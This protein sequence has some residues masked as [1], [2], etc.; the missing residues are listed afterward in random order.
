M[1]NIFKYSVF[2]IVFF[3]SAYLL[4]IVTKKI[5]TNPERKIGQA[6]DSLNGVVVYYNGGVDEVEGKD[7][8]ANYY[9]GLK[10]QC[11]EFVNRYYYQYYHHKMPNPFGNAVDFYDGDVKDGGLNKKTNLIQFLNPSKEN[12]KQGD[13]LIFNKSPG[14]KYGHIAIISSVNEHEIEIIQQNCG[15]YGSA[16]AKFALQVIGD[17]LYYIKSKKTL[18]RLRMPHL[19]F[20]K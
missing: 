9:L 19:P 1:K 3:V 12:P 8:S 6:I 18:G 14:N 11:V 20:L 2:V 17:T 4:F 10:Y 16:R 13:I 7:I 5:N 15:A